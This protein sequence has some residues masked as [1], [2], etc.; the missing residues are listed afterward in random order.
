MPQHDPEW[1]GI[2]FGHVGGEKICCCLRGQR[3]AAAMAPQAACS[4]LG[5][6]RKRTRTFVRACS[7]IYV[8]DKEFEGLN[9]NVVLERVDMLVLDWRW[10]L[11]FYKKVVHTIAQKPG[12]L[13]VFPR[14]GQVHLPRS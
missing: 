5:N 1:L 10:W 4:G 6:T 8:A 12:S 2:G 3:Q 9:A 7:N 14:A 13:L 11:C